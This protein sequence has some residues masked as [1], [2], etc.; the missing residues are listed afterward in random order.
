MKNCSVGVKLFNFWFYLIMVML[1]LENILR[2]INSGN[3]R[4]FHGKQPRM[5]VK[6]LLKSWMM[7]V[8]GI[9]ETRKGQ[10]GKEGEPEAS[11]GLAGSDCRRQ[12]ENVI[13]GWNACLPISLPKTIVYPYAKY[14]RS[15]NKISIFW[16][17]FLC[18]FD[19]SAVMIESL[20]TVR[21][22]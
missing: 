2:K 22:L 14:F 17:C 11:P 3:A 5:K 4:L 19:C 1:A 12:W 8:K 6:Y 18:K 15:V 21:R 7:V 20:C 13:H 10:R 9:V 16:L